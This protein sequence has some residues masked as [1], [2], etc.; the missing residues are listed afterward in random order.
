MDRGGKIMN[1]RA[2]LCVAVAALII[3]GGFWVGDLSAQSAE[4]KQGS[5]VVVY[6][7]YGNFRCKNCYN[8]EQWTKELVETTFKDKV[9]AGKLSFKMFNTDEAQNQHYLND[10][11]LYTKSVVLSLVKDGKE[12]RYDNLAKVWDCLKS[13][14]KFQNY[15]KGEIE[16]Y[17]KE[18]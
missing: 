4:I 12:V 8:M 5:S 2:L 9:D 6:Y 17:L 16:K 13:K 14:E 1:I 3:A 18:L 15:V 10:Y 7:F 11:K